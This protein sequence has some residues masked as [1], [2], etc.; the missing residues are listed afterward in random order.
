MLSDKGQKPYR[1]FVQTQPLAVPA[2]AYDLCDI[3]TVHTVELGTGPTKL[4]ADDAFMPSWPIFLTSETS[5]VHTV[6]VEP[7]ALFLLSTTW[8]PPSSVRDLKLPQGL[9]G[10]QSPRTRKSPRCISMWYQARLLSSLR[11][12]SS[13]VHFPLSAQPTACLF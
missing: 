6:S 12:S 5:P 3:H 1:S 2:G 11:N 4:K 9:P 13:P 10:N 8:Q 7:Q